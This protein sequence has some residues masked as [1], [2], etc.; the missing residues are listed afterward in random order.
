MMSKN[1]VFNLYKSLFAAL[2]R[3]LAPKEILE[4]LITRFKLN[5]LLLTMLKKEIAVK[6]VGIPATHRQSNMISK[7]IGFSLSCGEVFLYKIR[8]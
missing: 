2:A 3:T 8:I 5:F 1:Y 4:I 6:N 7:F